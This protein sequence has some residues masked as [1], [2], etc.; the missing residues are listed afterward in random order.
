MKE[1]KDEDD[2]CFGIAGMAIG[3][4]ILNGEDLLLGADL[5]D[6][7]GN[8]LTF[9]P[10]YYFQGSPLLGAS[11][12]WRITI[13]LYR[14]TI[15]M[16]LANIFCRSMHSGKVISYMEAKKALFSGIAEEGRRSCQLDDDEIRKLFQETYDYLRQVFIDTN[17]RTIAN[18]FSARLKDNRR[19]SNCEIKQL[20][21]MIDE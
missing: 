9:T 17:V 6:E 7:S 16:L 18:R 12:A 1:Y 15:G 3:I 5:D 21:G 11:E 19:L 2:K 20:L 14:M 8:Y 10:Y 4:S 13:N